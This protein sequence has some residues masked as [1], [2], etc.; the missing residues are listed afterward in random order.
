MAPPFFFFEASKKTF[1]RAQKNVCPPSPPTSA[2]ACAVLITLGVF[3]FSHLE[4]VKQRYYRIGRLWIEHDIQYRL[5]AA[6][7]IARATSPARGR[8]T[9]YTAV[10]NVPRPRGV[11]TPPSCACKRH[12]EIPTNR[13]KK[14]G[15]YGS[16]TSRR[17]DGKTQFSGVPRAAAVPGKTRPVRRLA[18]VPREPSPRRTRVISYLIVE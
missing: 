15:V 6:T 12:S 14:K 17:R 5:S 7:D 16:A 11:D 3:V 2:H 9:V 18:H 13:N 8:P 4:R 1:L 10:T